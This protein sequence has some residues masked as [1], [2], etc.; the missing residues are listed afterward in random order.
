MENGEPNLVAAGIHERRSNRSQFAPRRRAKKS[1]CARINDPPPGN[2]SL[3]AYANVHCA[4]TAAQRICR[5]VGQ[6]HFGVDRREYKPEAQASEFGRIGFTR[7]RFGLVFLTKAALSTL[8]DPN[9]GT[10]VFPTVAW[11][12]TV[13]TW[14]AT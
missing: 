13:R 3:D 12:P 8:E 10:P 14:I 1:A 7:L 11:F 5:L 4:G 2:Q 6:R 9:L